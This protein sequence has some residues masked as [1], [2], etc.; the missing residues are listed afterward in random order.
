MTLNLPDYMRRAHSAK[1]LRIQATQ[2]ILVSAKAAKAKDSVVAKVFEDHANVLAAE[3]ERLDN[4][5]K[6]H[7]L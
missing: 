4:I 3:A 2:S 1:E 6:K 7:A 5:M